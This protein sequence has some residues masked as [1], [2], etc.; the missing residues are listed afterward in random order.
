MKSTRPAD[1]RM[2]GGSEFLERWG[3]QAAPL[4]QRMIPALTDLFAVYRATAAP[5]P[6]SATLLDDEIRNL[7][8]LARFLIAHPH[9]P[10][11]ELDVILEEL[12]AA[13]L[14]GDSLTVVLMPDG[15]WVRSVKP[16]EWKRR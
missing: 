10:L 15:R 1:V 9:G 13:M 5:P 11:E 3:L 16:A 14:A 6:E 12:A 2:A 4:E 8:D 7:R